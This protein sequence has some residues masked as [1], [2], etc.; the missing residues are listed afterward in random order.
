MPK[1]MKLSSALIVSPSIKGEA[2]K[3]NPPDAVK[4]VYWFSL[5]VVYSERRNVGS[6]TAG[7][8]S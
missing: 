1:V 2:K 8:K 6:S 5:L 7:E 3:L 4:L